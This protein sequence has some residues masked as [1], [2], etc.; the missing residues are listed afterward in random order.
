MT[1]N[2]LRDK[3]TQSH[4]DSRHSASISRSRSR[5]ANI[6][7][8]RRKRPTAE[9]G[10]DEGEDAVMEEIE[11]LLNPRRRLLLGDVEDGD[12]DALTD[13]EDAVGGTVEDAGAEGGQ[14]A[15]GGDQ[16]GHEEGSSRS[17]ERPFGCMKRATYFEKLDQVKKCFQENTSGRFENLDVTLRLL[18]YFP[19]ASGILPHKMEMRLEST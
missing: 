13:E 8:A 11:V 6:R 7:W 17:K 9:M 19:E 16:A 12:P 15:G 1:P 14:D 2:T 4:R 3:N 18:R 10:D 5:S